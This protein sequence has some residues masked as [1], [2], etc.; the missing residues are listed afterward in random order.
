MFRSLILLGTVPTATSD[1]VDD[2]SKPNSATLASPIRYFAKCVDVCSVAS[3]QGLIN[4]E[5][6]ILA[7][8]PIYCSSAPHSYPARSASDRHLTVKPHRN[9]MID[10]EAT[11]CFQDVNDFFA[12]LRRH[13]FY[14]ALIAFTCAKQFSQHDVDCF[15]AHTTPNVIRFVGLVVTVR[16]K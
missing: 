12:S 6:V 16:F 7:R 3:D 9:R 4:H 1:S 8:A 2:P 5:L 15:A 13:H 11:T 14:P 10:N